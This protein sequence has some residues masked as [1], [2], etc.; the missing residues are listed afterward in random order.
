MRKVLL[1]LVVFIAVIAG[2]APF[3]DGYL[4][5]T[6]FMQRMAFMQQQMSNPNVKMELTEY[7]IG[8][9]QSIARIT[10]TSLPPTDKK[11]GITMPPMVFHIDSVIQH[12]PIILIDNKPVLAYANV[13]TTIHLPDIAAALIPDNGNGFMTINSL[14]SI[15][16]SQWLSNYTIPA[17]SFMGMAKWDG[18]TG[19]M[20]IEAP[21]RTPEKISSNFSIGALTVPVNP[22]M[23][24]LPEIFLSPMTYTMNAIVDASS[25]WSGS[26][27]L[28]SQ[29]LDVKW[30]DGR[31]IKAMKFAV[32]S[33]YGATGSMYNIASDI[34]LGSLQLPASSPVTTL[35]DFKYSISLDN[36]DVEGIK[37][38]KAFIGNTTGTPPADMQINKALAMLS[39]SSSLVTSSS[40]ATNLG[41]GQATIKLSL[42]N[43]PKSKDEVLND[44]NANIDARIASPLLDKM[45]TTY[46]ASKS[47]PA[48]LAPAAMN[49]M[50]AG[51]IQ[52][53]SA[54]PID[55]SQPVADEVTAAS[56][57]SDPTMVAK[58]VIDALVE[59]GYLVRDKNDYVI[60]FSKKGNTM[61]LNGKDVSDQKDALT[62]GLQQGL[63]TPPAA[64][65]SNVAQPVTDTMTQPTTDAQPVSTQPGVSG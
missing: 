32:H 2:V 40:I 24:S 18:L 49:T 11:T 31:I 35:T 61:T 28:S 16:G 53:P 46:L 17:V 36:L 6:I 50:A 64:A 58:Q 55:P 20:T 12:G 37:A 1:F 38:Y 63:A 48:Q 33:T 34:T 21:L 56:E 5:K 26:S 39:K 4:F 47:A 30:R 41:N 27:D 8:W 29:G 62:Q 45:V 25:L 3:L 19:N 22:A 23:P 15:D 10:V 14:V 51:D 43:A 57:P 7:K 65:P 52:Q 54:T 44:L 13:D 9:L 59:K 42:E 60:S